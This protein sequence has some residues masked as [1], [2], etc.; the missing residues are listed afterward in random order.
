MNPHQASRR[1]HRPGRREAG[2]V[3]LVDAALKRLE[4]RNP[5]INA[6]VARR[7]DAARAE[8][9]QLER[10]LAA[11][12]EPGPLAGVP[13]TVKEA[14]AVEGMPWT[15]GCRIF[16]GDLAERD[17]DAVAGLRRAG[18]IPIGVTNLSE[19]C[20]DYDSINPV[21]GATRNPHDTE[22]SAGGSSGGQAAAL[23]AGIVSLGVGS[24]IGGSIRFPAHLNGVVGLK[25]GGGV[26]P[27]QGH[28]P[29]PRPT[30]AFA[31]VVAKGH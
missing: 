16:D 3:E 2:P 7:D 24:D 15:G 5:A 6:V 8:A 26:V 30:P 29:G 23:A 25:A 31:L 21:Y 1:S 10:A 19:L 17:A 14:V 4:D 13:I 20:A 27:G 18:A 9:R 22:R 28:H 11:G 12:A